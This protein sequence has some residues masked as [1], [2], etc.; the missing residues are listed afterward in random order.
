MV[1]SIVVSP[2]TEP[3]GL[4]LAV[5]VGN[6][7]SVAFLEWIGMPA[8]NRVLGP[9]LRAGGRDGRV[10]SVLGLVLVVA[11]VVAMAVGFH[12]VVG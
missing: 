6:I 3:L 12:L 11:A 1:L 10:V 5:L 2:R 7:V 8:L 4:A 9:W